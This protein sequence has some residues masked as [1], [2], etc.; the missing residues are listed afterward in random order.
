MKSFRLSIL[1]LLLLHLVGLLLLSM[2]RL[3]QFV[4][5][6]SLMSTDS[7]PATVARAFLNGIW[8]DNVTACYIAIIP[9]IAILMAACIG[10]EKGIKKTRTACCIYMTVLY[11]IVFLISAANIPYYEFFSKNINSSIFN[12]FGYVATTAGMIFEEASFGFYLLLFLAASALY[13]WFALYINRYFNKLSPDISCR[14]IA[15]VTSQIVISVALIGLC[16]FGIRGR[17]GYNPIKISE[18]YF[19]NDPFL[20]QLGI[21]PAFNLLTSVLDDNRKENKE[22]HLLPYPEAISYARQSLGIH[23]NGQVDS[24]HVLHRIITNPGKPIRKN[25]VFILMESMSANFMQA[26]GQKLPIT[27]TLDSLY[28]HSLTFRNFYSA[29][30]HTNH[31]LTASLYSFPAIMKRNIMKG[32]VT[33]HYTGIPTVLKQQGYYNMFFMT[34]EA[35]YDNMNAFFR[36]NGYDAI[37][38]QENYPASAVVNSFGVPDRFLF[39][40]ALP[41]I[42]K[43]STSDKPFFA[44]LLTISNH[45]PYVIPKDFKTRTDNPETQIVEYADWCIGQF[46]KTARQKPWYRNTIFVLVADH[47]KR[48]GQDNSEL[49]ESFNHIPCMIFGEGIKEQVYTGLGGQIDIMPTLLGLLNISY[50]TDGFGIDLLKQRRNMIFYSADDIIVARNSTMRYL[51]KPSTAQSFCYPA[52]PTTETESLRKYV[53]GMLQTAEFIYQ[54]ANMKR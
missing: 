14:G 48:V 20:N 1:Y 2:F 13:G 32:T 24:L 54:K 36:S 11:S 8:F 19:C 51:Y 23:E 5:L 40:Y 16:A 27:P 35:Q 15:G 26:F 31:G 37:Y 10:K 41:K 47:G 45:P 43:A 22:L 39:N 28:H 33:P 34:H 4:G 53:F 12:W 50:E 18:A 9:L 7:T 38:S 29:G 21:N 42:D 30:I 6:H 44:T 52:R 25:V 49:Q 3:S 46:L 17:T